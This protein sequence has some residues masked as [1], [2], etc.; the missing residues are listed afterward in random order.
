[1]PIYRAL[2]S[3]ERRAGVQLPLERIR[4]G[5]IPIRRG[6]GHGPRY[7]L[8]ANDRSDEQWAMHDDIVRK[9]SCELPCR[10]VS[11][12]AKLADRLHEGLLCLKSQGLLAGASGIG[13][14]TSVAIFQPSGVLTHVTIIKNGFGV[15]VWPA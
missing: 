11:G 3:K 13:S 8:A 9:Q 1:M 12:L 14:A 15:A 2:P 5:I 6:G 7:G 10:G 4:P